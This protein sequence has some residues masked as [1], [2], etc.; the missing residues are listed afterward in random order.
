MH[1][2]IVLLLGVL[3]YGLSI[4]AMDNDEGWKAIIHPPAKATQIY[5]CRALTPEEEN[6][7]RKR[8]QAEKIAEIQEAYDRICAAKGIPTKSVEPEWA[9]KIYNDSYTKAWQEQCHLQ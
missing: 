7:Y 8:V 1:L 3:S 9:L 5:T 6:A 4:S 2:K